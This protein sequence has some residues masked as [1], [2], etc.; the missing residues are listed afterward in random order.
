[1]PGVI[2]T[3]LFCLVERN[4]KGMLG[5]EWSSTKKNASAH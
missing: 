5:E 4:I 3:M 2:E 1:M